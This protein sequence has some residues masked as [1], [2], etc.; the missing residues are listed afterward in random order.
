MKCIRTILFLLSVHL[1]ATEELVS[2]KKFLYGS[3][4]LAPGAGVSSRERVGQ[5]AKA[6]DLKLGVAAIPTFDEVTPLPILT[7]DYNWI[8]YTTSTEVSPYFSYGIGAAYIVPY[9]PLRAG[10]EFKNGFV[11][12]GAKMILGFLPSPELR[13]GYDFQF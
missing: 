8:Y 2:E 4:S 6:I 11:D 13:A 3:L 5:K 10:V 12:V 7:F 1:F 9:V